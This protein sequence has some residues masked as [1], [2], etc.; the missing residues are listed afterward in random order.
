[1]MSTPGYAGKVLFVDLTEKKTIVKPLEENMI[2]NFVGGWGIN[3]KFASEIIRGGTDPFSPENPIILGVGPMAGTLYPGSS[4]VMA[5]A[6]MPMT[7][8]ADGRHF[9]ATS[10][11]GSMRFS[12]M[13]KSAGYDHVVIQG[14]SPTPVYL[15][16]HDE[17]VE[18][19]D[20]QD[21]WGKLDIYQTA[22]HLFKRHEGYG[23]ITIGKAGENRVRFAMAIVDKTSHLGKSGFGAVMGAK[24]LKAIVVKGSGGVKPADPERFIKIV[25]Q[26]RHMPDNNPVA[27]GYQNIGLSASW[28]LIWVKNYYQSEKWTKAEWSSRYGV[29]S[30]EDVLHGI[31]ACTSCPVGCKAHHVVKKGPYEGTETYTTHYLY[32]A[33]VGAKLEIADPG[34]SIKFLDICNRSGMDALNA[35]SMIDWLTR[36]SE[37]GVISEQQT[38]GVKLS[39]DIDCYFL[40]LN[41]IIDRNGVGN[42]MADGWFALSN[43]VGRNATEDY[44]QQHGISKGQESIYPPRAA[45]M[46]PMRITGVMTNPFGGH[47]PQGHSASA[48]PERPIKILRRDAANTGMSE[49]ELNRTFTKDNFDHGRLTKHIED[50]YS[51]YNCLG[52]CSVWATFGYTTVEI[53]AEAY[54]ALT[55]IETTARELKEKG[56]KIINLYKM[57]NVREGFDRKDDI[58][59]KALLKPIQTPDG[60]QALTDYYRTKVYTSADLEEILDEYYQERGWDIKKGIPTVEKLCELGLQDFAN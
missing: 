18:I 46:D 57:L 39:R 28:D 2:K 3:Y 11:A 43:L 38:D 22:D 29:S 49:D 21:L 15:R 59:P 33:L 4:K 50:A 42:F 12:L 9:V 56:E 40:L 20:A 35:L 16:I 60:E 34:T 1:M 58:P 6:K 27:Q 13:L 51:V 37:E 53:L 54:S 7:A 48:A 36:L 24:N 19:C 32:A 47:T 23:T 17:E 14:R 55:G 10:T 44:A 25:D 30:V 45:K 41:K 26:V 5:T 31:K 52:V 8:S